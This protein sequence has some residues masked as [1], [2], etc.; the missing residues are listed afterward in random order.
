[1]EGETMKNDNKYL[2]PAEL[3]EEIKKNPVPYICTVVCLILFAVGLFLV[4][5]FHTPAPW[6]IG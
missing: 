2:T 3:I 4:T 5:D 1:V 6:W